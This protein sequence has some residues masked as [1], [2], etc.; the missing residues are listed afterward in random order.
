MKCFLCELKDSF[1]SEMR[2]R[3]L[4]V[5]VLEAKAMPSRLTMFLDNESLMS[6]GP[7]TMTSVLSEFNID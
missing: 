2:R 4:T 5:V 1:S 3:F 7:S 6:L